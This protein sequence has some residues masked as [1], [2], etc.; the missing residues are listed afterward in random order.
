[1]VGMTVPPIYAKNEDKIKRCGEWM[2]MQSRRIYDTVD[3]KVFK[4]M[5]NKVVQIKEEE[6]KKVE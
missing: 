3:E 6:E 5:K 1:M 4:K 2:K